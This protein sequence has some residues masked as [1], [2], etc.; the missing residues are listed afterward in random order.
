[1]AGGNGICRAI[2]VDGPVAKLIGVPA[3]RG[4]D[5]LPNSSL[6]GARSSTYGSQLTAN[7]RIAGFIWP[8]PS[9]TASA[10][11]PREMVPDWVM[12]E[13]STR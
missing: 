1:M 8:P 4:I 6:K 11:T 9:V 13:K 7:G 3:F 2:G 12:P 5:A 10:T